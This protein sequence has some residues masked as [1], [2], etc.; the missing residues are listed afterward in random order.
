MNHFRSGGQANRLAV[1]K[2]LTSKGGLS[3]KVFRRIY[4]TALWCCSQRSGTE[5]QGQSVCSQLYGEYAYGMGR[6]V[7]RKRT[8]IEVSKI[9]FTAVKPRGQRPRETKRNGQPDYWLRTARHKDG[10]NSVRA[11]PRN[12]RSSTAMVSQNTENL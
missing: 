8:V 2:G 11:L 6:G 9:T 10:K 7:E 1:R 5:R 4:Q 12:R 3:V